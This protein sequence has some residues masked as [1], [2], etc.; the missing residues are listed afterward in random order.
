MTDTNGKQGQVALAASGVSKAFPGVQALDDVSLTIPHNE[1]VGLL[2]DNGAGKSTL[3]RLLS[4]VLTPAEGTVRL[5][6]RELGRWSAPDLAQLLAVVPQDP[7]LPAG[8][9]AWEVVLMG[10]SPSSKVVCQSAPST[11]ITRMGFPRSS[12]S[13]R[14]T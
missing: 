12:R 1:I 6:G 2:G 8:F 14:V 4:R 11:S 7:D 9:T 3:V 10:R 13:K 5:N